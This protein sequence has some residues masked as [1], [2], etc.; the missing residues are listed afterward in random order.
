MNFTL[1]AYHWEILCLPH[2]T[3]LCVFQYK[4]QNNALYLNKHLYIFKLSDTKPCSFC[5]LEDETIIHLFANCSKSKTLFNSLKEFFKDI[6]LP[7]LTLQSA[8]FGFLQTEQELC[9]ILNYFY[10]HLNTT[11]MFQNV[12]KPL[13]VALKTNIK[14]TC[15]L[16][17]DL[18]KYDEKKKRFFL[19]KWGKVSIYF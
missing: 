18:S 14:K 2:N 13:L 9:L 15:I 6:N 12:L 4:V 17:K 19:K 10:R 8:N 16:E 5:N 1:F 3:R 7:S 11:Y